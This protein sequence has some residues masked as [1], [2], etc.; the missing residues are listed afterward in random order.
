M[1]FWR[2]ARP[3]GKANSRLS[4]HEYWYIISRHPILNRSFLKV[5]AAG[6]VK[7]VESNAFERE[8]GVC[9]VEGRRR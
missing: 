3:C 7:E 9:S 2:N 6:A 5:A 4:I 8:P 1:R